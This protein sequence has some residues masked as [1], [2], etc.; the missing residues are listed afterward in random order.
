MFFFDG[1]QNGGAPEKGRPRF[2]I[3]G[4]PLSQCFPGA[5]GTPRRSQVM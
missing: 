3:F 4:I 5:R 1:E 2:F